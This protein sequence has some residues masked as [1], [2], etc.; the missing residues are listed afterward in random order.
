MFHNLKKALNAKNVSIKA[1]AAVIG[2]CE[3]TAYNKINGDVE[4]TLSEAMTIKKEL[5]PEFDFDYLFSTGE[6]VGGRCGI[7]RKDDGKK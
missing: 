6:E 1:F 3:K 2:V 7:F 5:L 4:F